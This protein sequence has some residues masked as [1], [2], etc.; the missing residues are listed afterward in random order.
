VGVLSLL[1]LAVWLLVGVALYLRTSA[2]RERLRRIAVDVAQGSLQ[3]VEIGGA[4]ANPITGDFVLEHVVLRDEEGR[5]AVAIDEVRGRV[6]LL[7]LS[8]RTVRL[9]QLAL[10]RP[11]IDARPGRHGGSNLSELE[12]S[13]TLPSSPSWAIEIDHLLVRTGQGSFADDQGTV[14]S[15]ADVALDA[16]G[17]WAKAGGRLTVSALAARAKVAGRALSI[18]G[19]L[20]GTFNGSAI[21]ASLETLAVTGLSR[22][23]PLTLSG[24]A[25]GPLSSCWV[26]LEAGVGRRSRARVR[27]TLALGGPA[28]G[29]RLDL[30]LHAIDPACVLPGA[31]RGEASG[32]AAVQGSGFPPTAG[33]RAAVDL[34][35]TPSTLLGVRLRRALARG[36]LDGS[37]WH[38][39]RLRLDAPG[40]VAS[41]SGQGEG[42]RLRGHVHVD[43]ELASIAHLVPGA[44]GL[45]G[46]GVLDAQ[47]VG[48]AVEGGLSATATAAID[49]LRVDGGPSA[50]RIVARAQLTRWPGVPRGRLVV[51]SERVQL[52]PSLAPVES[53][54][55]DAHSNGDRSVRVALSATGGP[56][57]GR[58]EAE[59]SLSPGHAG[60]GPVLD[61]LV[62]K[63]DVDVSGHALDLL[64]PTRIRVALGDALTLEPT[65]L[66]VAGSVA[67]GRMQIA[68]TVS[69]RSAHPA[70]LAASF[71]VEGLTIAELPAELTPLSGQGR[72]T[73][74]AGQLAIAVQ[75]ALGKDG[76][77]MHAELH[78]PTR[79][80]PSL[81]PVLSPTGS[82]TLTA[83]V[84]RLPTPAAVSAALAAGAFSGG[85]TTLWLDAHGDLGE[86]RVTCDLRLDD[87]TVANLQ[88]A[89]AVAHLVLS[90]EETELD[91]RAGLAALDVF[92]GSARLGLG[93]R[94]LR[95]ALHG[96]AFDLD[97]PLS[98]HL[99][100]PQTPL[101]VFRGLSPSLAP[102]QGRVEGQVDLR[103]TLRH[104]AGRARLALSDLEAGDLPVG[105]LALSGSA[106]GQRAEV[107]LT[108][109]TG[110]GGTLDARLAAGLGA[111]MGGALDG[112]LDVSGLRVD[113]L[114]RL[115]PGLRE[116]AGRVDGHL[117]VGGT[118]G[119]PALTGDL[120]VADGRLGLVG[121]PTLKD[122]FAQLHVTPG[123]LVLEDLH[124]SAGGELT[125]H[126]FAAL[127]GWW[128]RTMHLDATARD[129]SFDFGGLSGYKV[130]G[131]LTLDG[132]ASSQGLDAKL[133]ISNGTLWVPSLGGGPALQSISPHP[134]LVFV[135]EGKSPAKGLSEPVP[136]GAGVKLGLPFSLALTVADLEV[137][138]H[139]LWL[140]TRGKLDVRSEG[141]GSPIVLKGAV[142][143]DHG[144]ITLAGQ[145]FSIRRAVA[146][147]SGDPSTTEPDL[148]LLLSHDYPDA[149]VTVGIR[150]TPS[151]P[152][153]DLRSDPPL[154]DRTQILSLLLTGMP[155]GQPEA[156]P[157]SGA[158]AAVAS[159]VIGQIAGH[160]A[161]A[162]RLDVLRVGGQAQRGVYGEPTGRTDTRVEMG[163]YIS[164]RIYVSYVHLFGASEVENQNEARVEYR[165]AR[166][167][168][169]ESAFGDA[170]AG[171]LDI[172]WSKRY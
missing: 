49:G 144:S 117:R 82:F 157:T 27:G 90:P 129:L 111:G 62:H 98:A 159:L 101:A 72:V 17:A 54:S 127:E 37:T 45:H 77:P 55:I 109:R 94:A 92:Q 123:Q 81:L 10:E 100:I 7:A 64:A 141:A 31:G 3:R 134:D 35:L 88:G 89:T 162:L 15:A 5:A 63:L 2:G 153:L 34:T 115:I 1:T 80:E 128:P 71:Q 70:R 118:L 140:A 6:D 149:S 58:T 142:H 33:A 124:L 106:D 120:A 61:V 9:T 50:R 16:S 52:T 164:D 24:H 66:S 56:V 166:R 57:Q 79:P 38:L 172:L 28:V 148:D 13:E 137:R 125:A 19:A 160:I 73:T 146:R 110:L 122:I 96:R 59:L 158:E 76:V 169:L 99:T 51:T 145:K 167:W 21:D 131:K 95:A 86:P 41:A 138:S 170:G 11:V 47:V 30:A 26:D 121:Q 74:S 36:D 126:G 156:T 119:A 102:V 25:G 97:T 161:P 139:D 152:K 150:G 93:S 48:E 29:Y 135:E 22:C 65:S 4:S 32:Q 69:L 23:G 20:R 103:G 104:P 155:G 132:G 114:A 147:W 39:S 105:D 163:K 108:T 44:T 168:I 154:Y 151:N 171:G 18:R 12:R 85:F 8:R 112:S 107:H 67:G 42:R 68:G 116:A 87:V 143:G 91:L 78:L 46:S 75:A 83:A 53:L 40:F 14:L 113:A 136:A 165:F 60:P 84:H 133:E 130:G 43:G